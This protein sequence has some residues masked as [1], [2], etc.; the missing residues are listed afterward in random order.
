[1]RGIIGKFAAP[2]LRW[3]AKSDPNPVVRKQAATLAR[4]IR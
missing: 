3:A 4:Y 2:H 1:L